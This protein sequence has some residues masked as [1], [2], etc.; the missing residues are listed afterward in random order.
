MDELVQAIIF[1]RDTDFFIAHHD[2]PYTNHLAGVLTK[3]HIN[4][5]D[6]YRSGV[7]AL[8]AHEHYTL[9]IPTS[10]KI[11]QNNGEI[12]PDRTVI[13]APYAKS[14]SN[15]PL[16]FWEETVRRKIREGFRVLTNTVGGEEPIA[17]TEA[18]TIPITKMISATEQAG[19]F[20]GVRSGLCDVLITAK[21]NKTVIFP[22]SFY[23]FT[24][25]KVSEFFALDGWE[26][27]VI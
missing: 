3:K 8:S 21:C 14:V 25:M 23:S 19:F 20:I 4:F 26:T 5:H 15:I 12:I 9:S 16:S 17:G 13:I 10:N 22:N 11:Y 1:M 7:F 2:R 18:I 27:I 6:L 24:D